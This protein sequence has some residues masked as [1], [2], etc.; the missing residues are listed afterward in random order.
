MVNRWEVAVPLLASLA[1]S[2]LA[3]GATPP[4]VA[5]SAAEAFE[6]SP[7]GTYECWPAED[8]AAPDSLA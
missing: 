2:L 7:H 4:K 5:A 8:E 1:L 3:S 6:G